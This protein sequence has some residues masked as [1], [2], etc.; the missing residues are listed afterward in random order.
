LLRFKDER[1]A[2]VAVDP[3]KA[4]RAIPVVLKYAALK[5]IVVL[6]VIGAAAV[7]RLDPDQSA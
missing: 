5:N 1:A 4:G 2:L 3:T 6:R 7:R